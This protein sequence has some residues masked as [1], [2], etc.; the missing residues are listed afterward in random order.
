MIAAVIFLA[1]N[2][3]TL[4]QMDKIVEYLWTLAAIAVLFLNKWTRSI[5]K[6]AFIKWL[7]DEAVIE[8]QR[9]LTD[10]IKHTVDMLQAIE[11]KLVKTTSTIESIQQA[12]GSLAGELRELKRH[13]NDFH[14]FNAKL[15]ER[16]ATL[17]AKCKIS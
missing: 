17:E 4:Q 12:M 5:I 3:P 2:D 6:K 13:E 14:E 11:V 1:A 9:K 15:R 7:Q 16:V 8:Q 10:D